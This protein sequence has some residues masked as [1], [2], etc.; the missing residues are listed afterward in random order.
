[1]FA[2]ALLGGVAARI[3]WDNYHQGRSSY[4][5]IAILPLMLMCIETLVPAPRYLRTVQSEILIHAPSQVVWDNI[6]SVRA[7]EKS[8]LRLSTHFNVYAAHWTDAVMQSIQRQ[9]LEVI[10]KRCERDAQATR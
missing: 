8:E 7:I 4:S 10:R 9:I 1:M 2:C 6:K 3:G 5:A